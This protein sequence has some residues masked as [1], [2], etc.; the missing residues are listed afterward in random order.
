MD[1]VQ[2]ADFGEVRQGA[3][4]TIDWVKSP[5]RAGRQHGCGRKKL[6]IERPRTEALM[7][8]EAGAGPGP[9][10]TYLSAGGGVASVSGGVSVGAVFLSAFS[11]FFFFFSI[12]R[13]RFSYW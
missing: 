13:C 1:L 8:A 3:G 2:I 9:A 12:S 4:I 6:R 11:A 5:G 10:L 7:Q